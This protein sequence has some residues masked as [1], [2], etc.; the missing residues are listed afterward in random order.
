MTEQEA[1][2]EEDIPELQ[3]LG[4]GSEGVAYSHFN[5]VIKYTDEPREVS[6]ARRLFRNPIPCTV[7]VL[8]EPRIL[9]DNR[10]DFLAAIELERVQ[11]LSPAE[12][13]VL[14]DFSRSY[15]FYGDAETLR[16]KNEL[17]QSWNTYQDF[18]PDQQLFQETINKLTDEYKTMAECLRANHF[19]PDDAHPWNLGRNKEGH[20]VLLDLGH[21]D[22]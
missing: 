15:R 19:S 5:G 16:T 4:Q 22:G 10:N 2:Q 12:R 13:E 17:L 21:S 3:Y 11:P 6:S 18:F 20:L 9:H 1:K 8:S 14:Y 7:K